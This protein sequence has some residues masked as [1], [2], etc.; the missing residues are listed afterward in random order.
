MAKR[1]C[2]EIKNKINELDNNL[3]HILAL[4]TGITIYSVMLD[5]YVMSVTN[6]LPKMEVFAKLFV[7]S[8]LYCIIELIVSSFICGSLHYKF[9]QI[10]EVLDKIDSNSLSESEYRE[11]LMFSN[12]CHKTRFGFTIGGMAHIQK[13]TLIPV[14]I[15]ILIIH[16]I[17]YLF[18]R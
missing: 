9:E 17:N 11:W 16:Q 7:F 13:T 10:S 1:R 4:R 2:L 3:S 8:S 12:V 18:H 14:C 6:G 15:R 5:I